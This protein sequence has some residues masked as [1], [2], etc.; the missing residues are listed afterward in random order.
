MKICMILSVPFP[1]NEGIGYYTYNLS[2]KLLEKGHE[3]VVITRGSFKK[4]QT[5]IFNNIEIIRAPYVPIYPQKRKKPGN[6]RRDSRKG[7]IKFA[8]G[9]KQSRK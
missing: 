5:E 9:N 3:V 1:P 8:P 4:T 7:Q 2:K 6:L